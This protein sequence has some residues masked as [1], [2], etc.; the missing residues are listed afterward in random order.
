M[1]L[2]PDVAMKTDE[3]LHVNNTKQFRL[4]LEVPHAN[5]DTAVVAAWCYCF[6]NEPIVLSRN[7]SWLAFK[8]E[9]RGRKFTT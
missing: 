9:K 5:D 4:L 1:K 2:L 8:K 6:D 3:I 7:R